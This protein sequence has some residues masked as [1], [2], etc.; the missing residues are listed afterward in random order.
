[1]TEADARQQLVDAMRTLDARGLNRGTSGNLSVRFGSGMFVTPSGVTPDRL[2]PD[3]TV[4]VDADGSVA[5]GAARPSS[6]WQM[7]MGIYLRRADAQAIVH[8]HA[9]HSTILACAHRE[10]PPLHYMVAVGGGAS[11]PVAPYA[12]FGSDELA[13]HVVQT[14]EGRRACLMA[15]HGLIALGPSLPL[16]MAIAEEIEEQAAVYC[17]TLAIG[18]PKLL[19]HAEMDRILDAFGR[20]GQRDREPGKATGND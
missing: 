6:E 8:C 18:G 15:N 4:F 16:A 19:D 2:T 9:R 10:I 13:G 1:M 7:H 14:L 20:Y 17:G 3:M 5:A 11:V 12:T